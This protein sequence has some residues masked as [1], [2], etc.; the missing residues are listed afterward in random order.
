M[1]RQ[2]SGTGRGHSMT[3]CHC[4]QRYRA[5]ALPSVRSVLGGRAPF[6]SSAEKPV[7]KSRECDE[8][9]SLQEGLGLAETR[10]KPCC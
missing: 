1:R 2:C 7:W 3:F 4:V 8:E 5:L 10:G 9:A 6:H